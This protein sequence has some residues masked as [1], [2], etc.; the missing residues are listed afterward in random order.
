MRTSR[1]FTLVE[2]LVVIAIIGLLASIVMVGLGGAK[3]KSR[4]GKRVADIANIKLALS[5][6][7]NDNLFYPKNIYA[8][9]GTGSDSANGL[10]PAYLPTVPKDPN[11]VAGTDCNVNGLNTIASCYHYS[12]II[13]GG[14]GVCGATSV[15]VTYHLSATLEDTSNPALTQ[16]VDAGAGL[17]PPYAVSTFSSCGSSAPGGFVGTDPIYDVIP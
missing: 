16:D 9:S 13:S 14:N 11:A 12:P 6:Y 7:Y 5:L 2:L 10:A 15:F 1:G 3:Q 8:P 4:D 17:N